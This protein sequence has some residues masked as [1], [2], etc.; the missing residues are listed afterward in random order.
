[1]TTLLG[2]TLLMAAGVAFSQ[3]PPPRLHV[4]MISLGV[5]DMDRS[6]KFYRETLGLP[7]LGKPGVVTQFQAGDV[8]IALNGPLGRAAG[9]AMVG[10]V[11]IVFPVQSVAKVRADLA[12]RGC[13]FL[14]EPREIFPGTWGATFTDPDGHRL[15]ILGPQ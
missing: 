8:T 6:V 9:D 7:I 14:N 2:I 13:I 12:G 11:E 1:M 10:A 5:R 15:T 3:T 4:S